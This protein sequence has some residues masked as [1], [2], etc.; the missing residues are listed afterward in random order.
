MKGAET[1]NEDLIEQLDRTIRSIGELIA[2]HKLL[3]T[4]LEKEMEKE[5]EE[6]RR[7]KNKKVVDPRNNTLQIRRRDLVQASRVSYGR[8]A[9]NGASG[10]GQGRRRFPRRIDRLWVLL[11]ESL[12]ILYRSLG[13]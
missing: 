13:F 8:P 9:E 2:S 3:V 7:E 5:E 11:L 4:E 10:R 12:V 6:E 1:R